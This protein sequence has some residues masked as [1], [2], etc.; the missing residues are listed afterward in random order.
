MVDGAAA[1]VEVMELLGEIGEDNSVPK[2]V[3]AKIKNAFSALDQKGKSVPVKINA[4]IQELDECS[5]NPNIP[6]YVRTQI[7]DIVSRLESI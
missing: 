4:S 1:L 5:D 7:W 3:R 6:A 2:N